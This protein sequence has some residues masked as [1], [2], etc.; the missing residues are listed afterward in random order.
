[1]TSRAPWRDPSPTEANPRRASPNHSQPHEEH[2]E[3]PRADNRGSGRPPR[4]SAF[5]D[6]ASLFS[7]GCARVVPGGVAGEGEHCVRT[8]EEAC[9]LVIVP[10]L[11]AFSGRELGQWCDLRLQAAGRY[12]LMRPARTVRRCISSFGVGKAITF[13]SS[14]GSLLSTCRTTPS[15]GLP[16][17]TTLGVTSAYPARSLMGSSNRAGRAAAS[18]C[19]PRG[20]P[21]GER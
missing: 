20:R 8:F 19:R 13:G 10:D 17:R 11:G 3:A 18:P 12:S 9:F 2:I 6:N 15:S 1:M 16:R 7:M 4:R 5:P 14:F 21:V